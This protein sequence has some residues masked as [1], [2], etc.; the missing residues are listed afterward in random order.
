MT[1]PQDRVSES[2]SR[3]IQEK[4]SAVGITIRDDSGRASVTQTG[5]P[6]NNFVLASTGTF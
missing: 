6:L 1:S 2:I 3:E 5:A 4:N